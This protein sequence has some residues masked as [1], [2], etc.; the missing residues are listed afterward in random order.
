MGIID[1]ALTRILRRL[2]IEAQIRE[3]ASIRRDARETAEDARHAAQRADESR[4][5]AEVDAIRAQVCGAMARHHADMLREAEADLAALR[6][7]P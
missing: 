1:A 3:V 4:A 2:A 5:E 6:R 7:E